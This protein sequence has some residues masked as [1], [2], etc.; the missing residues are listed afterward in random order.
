MRRGAAAN[1]ARLLCNKVEVF[2]RANSLWF[3]NCEEALVDFGWNG[4]M[5]RQ[6]PINEYQVR[7]RS[8]ELLSL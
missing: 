7:G 8:H 5:G 3:A 1:K 4:K 2:H 6:R